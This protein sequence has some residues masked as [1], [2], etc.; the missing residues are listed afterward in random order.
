MV[1]FCTDSFF[2]QS[3][4]IFF[5]QIEVRSKKST[6][7]DVQE[8]EGDKETQVLRKFSIPIKTQHSF[9][10]FFFFYAHNTNS[11]HDQTHRH[12]EEITLHELNPRWRKRERLIPEWKRLVSC[13]RIVSYHGDWLDRTG[14]NYRRAWWKSVARPRRGNPG[15]AAGYRFIGIY[16]QLAGHGLPNFD[17]ITRNTRALAASKRGTKIISSW[18]AVRMLRNI[19][20]RRGKLNVCVA[21]RIVGNF[22]TRFSTD[23]SIISCYNYRKILIKLEF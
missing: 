22:S 16:L 17:L 15:R 14:G 5:S 8:I 20:E 9:P 23:W 6:R 1:Y 3:T 11:I 12:T 4:S 13:T 10:L 2:L 19:H 7:W 21:E 18:S